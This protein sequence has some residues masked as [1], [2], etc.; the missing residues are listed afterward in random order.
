MKRW[1]SIVLLLLSL[2]NTVAQ[3]QFVE[4]FNAMYL[5]MAQGLPNNFV[6]HL[7]ADS[8]GFVW[9]ATYG[10]G[11]VRYD[12]FTVMDFGAGNRGISLHSNSCRNMTEDNFH[13]LWVS[14]DEYTEVLDLQTLRPV[15][16]SGE[17][18]SLEQILKQRSVRV[19]HDTQGKIWI[20]TISQIACVEFEKDGSVRKIHTFAY[21]CDLPDMVVRDVDENGTVWVSGSGGEVFRL[22]LKNG[23]LTRSPVSSAIGNAISHVFVTDII[24]KNDRIWISTNDGLFVYDPYNNKVEVFRHGL[25][26]GSLSHNYVLSLVV[27]EEGRL[28]VGTLNGVD[29][30]DEM[31]GTFEHWNTGSRVHPLPSNFV[32]CLFTF[33][34]QIWVGTETGGVVRLVPRRLLLR[35]FIHTDDP[36]S[37]SPNAVNAMYATPD[38][39]LWVGTVEGGLNLREPGQSVFTHFTTANSALTHNSVSAL[40]ADRHHR[41]WIGTWGGGMN[42]MSLD[43]GNPKAGPQPLVVEESFRSRL[44][45]IGTLA[46]DSINDGIWIGSNDGVYFYDL[47]KETVVEPFPGSRNIRGCIGSIVDQKGNLWMG[48]IEGTIVIDLKKRDRAAQGGFSYRQMRYK[49]DNPKSGILEK[50]SCFC[51][52]RDGS[53][54]LGSSAYGLYHQSVDQQGVETFKAYTVE[55]GLSNNSVKGIVEAED[56]TLWITTV[57]GLSHFNPK[58]GLFTN[59]TESDGLVSSQFYWNSAVGMPHGGQLFLGSDKGLTE[60]SATQSVGIY[61]G[62]LHFTRLLIAN[63]L[64]TSES[65]SLQRDISCADKMVIHESDKSFTIE[66]SAL[67]YGSELQGT[68][69]YRMKGFEDDWLLLPPGQHSVRYTNLPSGDYEFQVKYVS[70]MDKGAENQ[71]SMRVKVKPYFWKSWWFITLLS[72]LTMVVLVRVYLNRVDALRRNEA[73][74]LFQPLEQALRDMESPQLLQKRIQSIIDNHRKVKRSQEKSVEADKE[75]LAAEQVPFVD[76]LIGI[77]EKNY[78]DPEFGVPELCDMMGMSRAALAKRVNVEMGMPTTQ[79]IRNYR[80][81]VA[82]SMLMDNTNKNRNIAEIAYQVGFNDPKYFTRCFTNLFGVSPRSFLTNS[83]TK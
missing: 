10:G 17:E 19:Y 81:D 72:L 49:L 68:Y 79:F 48:C 69:S 65:S 21:P 43:A 59:Y 26:L 51:L 22:S 66:F 74:K 8:E 3:A 12:G 57:H 44:H 47:R 52:S 13:R 50:I 75:E 64:V 53:L 11:L 36:A 58:T 7:F 76:R 46:Y 28:L 40:V 54:W 38:G 4:R 15:V 60:L 80:L 14:F 32:N 29:I 82:K 20:V 25:E 24:K 34:G 78:S 27:S 9:I 41:L 39:R 45:F 67:D 35:N 5:N 1:W 23:V 31:T 55:N 30:L 70:A 42:W 37:L 56:G 83:E 63:Q 18:Q 73:E 61:R 77:M 33:H 71:I 2:G 6:D 16:P 62:S